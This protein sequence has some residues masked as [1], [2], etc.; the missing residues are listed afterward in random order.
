M[1]EI[2]QNN[3]KHYFEQQKVKISTKN[4]FDHPFVGKF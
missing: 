1:H 3:K 4:I 2:S